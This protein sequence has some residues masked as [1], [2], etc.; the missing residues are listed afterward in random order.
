MVM[1]KALTFLAR[2]FVAG[3]TAEEAIEAIRR[4]NKQGLKATLDFL[5]EEVE[6]EEQAGGATK[7]ISRLFE[8]IHRAK[9]DSNVSIKLSQMGLGI[10]PLMARRNLEKVLD[11]AAAH[12]NFV[13]IDMEGSKHTQKTLDL[14]Y[15]AFEKRK[16]VGIVIQS[17]LR[18]S[19]ADVEEIC[20]RGAGVRLCK[21]AYKEPREIAFPKKEEV[22]ESYDRLTEI[23]LE[24]GART[25][26]ATHDDARIEFAQKAAR[27][28]GRKLDSF[29]IQML[30]GLRKKRWAELVRQGHAVR[31]YVPY[32]THWMPYYFRRLR[33]RK[34]NV[35]FV[36]KNLLW[37]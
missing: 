35:L 21:G 20:K 3:E 26:L 23:L 24:K 6:T 1:T 4:L 29:E 36:L 33:E 13:R 8:L 18:R 16:N 25:G 10:D 12:G 34:E 5:G 31:I 11:A 22:N 27:R 32:G 30:Y 19:L 2:R 15:A 7:E 37:G 9:V 14:F 28:L 17:Y